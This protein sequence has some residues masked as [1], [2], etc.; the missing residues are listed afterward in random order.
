MCHVYLDYNRVIL[1]QVVVCLYIMIFFIK[2]AKS[3]VYLKKISVDNGLLWFSIQYPEIFSL[4]SI[5]PHV[6]YVL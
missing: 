2:L 6:I 1:Y 5:P 3:A 4:T